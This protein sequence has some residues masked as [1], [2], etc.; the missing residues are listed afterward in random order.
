MTNIQTEVFWRIR[1]WREAPQYR[2]DVPIASEA[3]DPEEA[4]K[5][6]IARANQ[7][8]WVAG[9]PP[10]TE[11]QEQVYRR[12]IMPLLKRGM[13]AA[14]DQ[15]D[16]VLILREW[17]LE[18]LFALGALSEAAALLIEIDAEQGGWEDR[19]GYARVATEILSKRRELDAIDPFLIASGLLEEDRLDL[20]VS[21]VTPR[22]KTFTATLRKRL[23]DFGYGVSPMVSSVL[24]T[25]FAFYSRAAE[26]VDLAYDVVAL[27]TDVRIRLHRLV[28]LARA[29]GQRKI[30][31][32]A[33][34]AI[35]RTPGR[36]TRMHL[37]DHVLSA[38]VDA[39]EPSWMRK[40]RLATGVN[41]RLVKD[42]R[43]RLPHDKWRRELDRRLGR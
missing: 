31:E 6:R 19:N 21:V 24:F 35:R 10:F 9:I 3:S 17:V 40:H 5:D 8:R 28:D 34:N 1:M 14:D 37:Y 29:S 38:L 27:I 4:M 32:E 20:L 22:R 25:K 42:I 30:Y 33:M 11:Q 36:E 7:L 16:A 26:D 15:E 39:R 12:E 13:N 41:S 2:F 43:E 23:V 18:E